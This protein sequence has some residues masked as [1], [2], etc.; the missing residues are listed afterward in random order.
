MWIKKTIGEQRK[1]LVTLFEPQMRELSKK[2]AEVWTS[3]DELDQVLSKEFSTI[4]HC[5]L[6]YA[7]DKLGKQVSSNINATV[8]APNYRGQDL[9]R[10]PYSVSLYPKRQFML[11]SVYISQASGRPCISAVQPVVNEQ[12]FLGFVVA[13][14]DIRH[15][16]LF[17]SPSSNSLWQPPKT[18]TPGQQKNVPIYQRVDSLFDRNINDVH[19]A[20]EKLIVEHG[21]FHCTIHYASVQVMLWQVDDPYQYRLYSLEQILDPDM[22]LAYSRRPYSARAKIFA[23][24]VKQVLERFRLLRQADEGIYLRSG[25]IN[26][27]NGMVGLSFSCEGSQYMLSEVFLNRNTSFWLGKHTEVVNG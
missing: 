3:P 15:L 10:R 7:I 11:S 16:P 22:Y 4:P 26:I 2:C 6:I 24:Q 18:P 14:F 9:S 8:I 1:A 23:G 17:V 19:K 21:V 25:S 27:I 5:H 13:D 20:L 12:Q